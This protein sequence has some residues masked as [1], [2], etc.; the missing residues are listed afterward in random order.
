MVVGRLESQNGKHSNGRVEGGQAVDQGDDH[1][2]LLTVV[3]GGHTHIVP[4][5]SGPLRTHP[6][7][8]HPAHGA[9]MPAALSAGAVPDSLR[10]GSDPSPL[11]LSLPT[12][13]C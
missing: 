1:C 5:C 10:T 2:V 8:P 13:P 12:P 7:T 9:G 6:P 4:L 3:P 11:T